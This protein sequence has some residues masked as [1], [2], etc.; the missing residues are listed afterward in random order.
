M[1]AYTLARWHV[2]LINFFFQFIRT[3]RLSLFNTERGRFM[4]VFAMWIPSERESNVGDCCQKAQGSLSTSMKMFSSTQTI[5]L[6]KHP[7]TQISSPPAPFLDLSLH[8]FAGI[9][10]EHFL[11]FLHSIYAIY[12]F[13]YG[14]SS[15]FSSTENLFFS[16]STTTIRQLA[17]T[18]TTTTTSTTS[19]RNRTNI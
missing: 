4:G 14:F 13:S 18:T 10:V 6:H 7:Y 17:T 12:T 11:S 5:I 2:N 15:I 9:L 3:F 1:A 8:I 16:E 19:I